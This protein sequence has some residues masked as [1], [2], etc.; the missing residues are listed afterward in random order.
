MTTKITKLTTKRKAFV[1]GIISGKSQ[2]RAY[3]DAYNTKGKPETVDPKASNL[4]RQPSIQEV[5]RPLLEEHNLTLDRALKPLDDAL[6]A[7]EIKFNEV[8]G[9]IIK[10]PNH[11]VRIQA[12]DRVLKLHG[13]GQQSSPKNLIN[14]ISMQKDQYLE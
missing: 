8:T 13:L 9:E 14:I 6:D 4:I 12:S 1:K 7:T 2:R 5:L 10:Q 11:S 3:I